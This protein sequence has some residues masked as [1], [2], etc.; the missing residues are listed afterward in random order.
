VTTLE[1][2]MA[3]VTT[4]SSFTGCWLW[5]GGT[6]GTGGN[7]YGNFTIKDKTGKQRW[8]S[9]HRFSYSAFKGKIGKGLVILHSCDE[10]LCVNPDHLEANT[11]GK[12]MQDMVSRGRNRNGK[13]IHRTIALRIRQDKAYGLTYAEL[14][15]RYQDVSP[16]MIVAICRGEWRPKKANGIHVPVP[17]DFSKPV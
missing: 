11:Q 8:V 14:T 3:K 1:R 2:F 12:N 10:P 5:L 17:V 7:K 16:R 13:R 4:D 9:A 15:Q 6:K